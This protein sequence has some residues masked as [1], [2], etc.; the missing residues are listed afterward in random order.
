MTRDVIHALAL[1]PDSRVD[2][3]VP[4]K[5]L[6]EN[7]APTS[8]DKRQ[9]N[10]GIEEVV[11]LAA[12]KPTNIGVPAFRDGAREYLE[13]AVVSAVLRSPAKTS[14]I[15]E[16]VHRAIPYPVLLVTTLA[17][18]VTVSVAHKRWSQG[19]A[20]RV[21]LDDQVSTAVLAGT[22]E[23]SAFLAA[24]PLSGLP[25]QNLHALYQ[26]WLDAIAAL[27]AARLTGSFVV[28]ETAE[29][30]SL[31]RAALDEHARIQREI[32]GLRIAAKRE[33]QIHRRVELNLAIQKLEA[34]LAKIA[35]NL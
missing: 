14:R 28:A 17:E 18:T 22:S 34:Q 35:G 10:E 6:V 9:I 20:G 12:L 4:K 29:A 2:Q 31:R 19:E 32:A 11:W 24:L 25:R 33:R 15:V 1:P 7:G 21:V 8:A 23:E 3:R 13:I 26:G 5:H 27:A 30:T 16:L